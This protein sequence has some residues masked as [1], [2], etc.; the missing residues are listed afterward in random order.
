[1]VLRYVGIA[2]V[3]LCVLPDTALACACG[4]GVF[5]VGTNSLLPKEGNSGGAVYFE[6]DHSNQT[7]NWNGTSKASPNDNGDKNIRTDWYVLGLNYMFNRDWGV[8]VRIPTANRSFLTDN[9]YPEAPG[10]PADIARYHMSTVGDIEV[11]GTYTGFSNDLSKGVIFGLR[12]PTGDWKAP[13]F[14]RDVEVGSGSTELVLGGFWRGMITGDNAWQYFVQTRG[15]VALLTHSEA[16]ATFGAEPGNY[17]PGLQFDTSF[18]VLYNNWLKVGPL[19]RVAPIFQ[20]IINHHEPDS[21][22]AADP[23][24]SGYDRIFLSP[25]FDI[26]KVIDDANNNTFKLY[27]DIE[28]PIYQRMNGNQLVQPYLARIIASYTF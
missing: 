22:A 15:A 23:A 8:N 13:G 6:W 28:I 3:F 25:G 5:E 1:M 26:T 16:I 18:G 14:D 24:N 11:T 9:N 21:G 17:R 27:G 12:L 4:C 19:D 2:L 20:V 10:Q 7:T